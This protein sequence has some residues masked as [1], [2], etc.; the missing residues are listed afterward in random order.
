MITFL[1]H[2]GYVADVLSTTSKLGT[3]AFIFLLLLKEL[4]FDLITIN[5][6]TLSLFR[7]PCFK[8]VVTSDT[9][10]DNDACVYVYGRSL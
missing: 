4:F 6:N 8:N 3:V 10:R 1:I 7:V 9:P 5:S 2:I